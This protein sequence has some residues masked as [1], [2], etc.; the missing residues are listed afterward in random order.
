MT[1]KKEEVKAPL[2]TVWEIIKD[3]K[4]DIFALPHQTVANH[5]T[6]T[7]NMSKIDPSKAYVVPKSSAVLPA[8]ELTLQALRERDPSKAFEVSQVDKWL[9]I[10]KAS[11]VH[12]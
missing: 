7:E 3:L 11:N 10:S 6:L 9:V 8:L 4:I 1:D 5:C 2:N 12:F